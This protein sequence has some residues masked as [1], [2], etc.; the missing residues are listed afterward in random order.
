MNARIIQTY[1]ME[2]IALKKTLIGSKWHDL[3]FKSLK[4][5]HF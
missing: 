3:I 2:E 5:A 4:N 1:Y